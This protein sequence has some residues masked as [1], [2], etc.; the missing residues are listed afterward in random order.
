MVWGADFGLGTQGWIKRGM[1]WEFRPEHP[2]GPCHRS[3]HSRLIEAFDDLPRG[4]CV[5]GNVSAGA[6]AL[7]PGSYEACWCQEV[8]SSR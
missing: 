2:K 6:V 1:T 7:D 8:C 5:A 3:R 4:D